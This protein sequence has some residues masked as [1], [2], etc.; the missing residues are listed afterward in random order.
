MNFISSSLGEAGCNSTGQRTAAMLKAKLPGLSQVPFPHPLLDQTKIC[1]D[2]I[3][4]RQ[5][6]SAVRD[7]AKSFHLLAIRDEGKR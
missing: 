1:K 6:R 3:H 5:H 7:V 2:A 4:R